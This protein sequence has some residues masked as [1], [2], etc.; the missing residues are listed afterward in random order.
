MAAKRPGLGKGLDA[1][2]PSHP[3]GEILEEFGG[4]LEVPLGLI[5]ANP[6]Q[7]RRS[8][9]EEKLKELAA[10]IKE[11]G[12]IQPLVLSAQDTDEE[13]KYS[14]IAGERRLRAAHLAGLKTVPAVLREAD[15]QDHLL[16]ALIE[17]VQRA[18]LNPLET[19]TA[20]QSLAIEFSLSHKEIGKRVGKSRTAVTNTLRLLD[21]PDVVQQAVRKNQISMGH[22]RA[23]L[24]LP[25]IKGQSAALQTILTQ[26]LNVRQTESLV[27]RLKGTKNPRPPKNDTKSPELK[28]LEEDLQS[29]LGTKVR[30]TRS[31]KGAGTITVSYY[32][33]E[34][35]NTLMDQF[36]K[37]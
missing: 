23:L 12:I 30:I 20:Y 7:P 21:L 14:L 32:T 6:H 2:I 35:L 24:A 15:G 26:D 36:L 9:D 31:K 37:K 34:E 17:N 11:H 33:D 10:S 18:D 5:A 4:V 27:T 19:A 28:A 25:T 22:A 29:A 13:Q 16:L 1:L 8:F 3:E